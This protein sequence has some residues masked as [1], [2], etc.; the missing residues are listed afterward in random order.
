MN[1]HD[2]IKKM[3]EVRLPQPDHFLIVRETLTR[4]GIVESDGK[5]LC[6]LCHIL[7]KQGRYFITHFKELFALDGQP[8]DFNGADEERRNMV[9]VLLANWKLVQPVDAEYEKKPVAPISEIKIVPFSEKAEW[10]FTSK[11]ALG[12]HKTPQRSYRRD[13]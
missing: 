11:Y 9:V 13:H 7:H 3:V 10:T 2:V 12:K 1:Q 8:S 4:I 6:Q 5:T